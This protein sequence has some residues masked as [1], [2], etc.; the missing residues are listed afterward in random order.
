MFEEPADLVL[1]IPL[2]LNVTALLSRLFVVNL[3]TAR[4]IG[5]ELP[6]N[7]IDFKTSRADEC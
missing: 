1:K 7:L 4:S 6:P 2:D 5:L 3:K